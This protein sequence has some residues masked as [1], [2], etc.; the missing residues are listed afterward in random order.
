MKIKSILPHL[1][2]V[3]LFTIIS[4]AY[5][6]PVLEG[7]VLKANDSMVA[8]INAKE[9]QDFRQEFGKEPLWTNALFS[10]M[11][12][13]LISTKYPGNIFK[14]IDTALRIYGMP[15][16]VLFLSMLGFYFLLLMLGVNPWLSIAGGVGYGLSSFLLQI[17]AAG[18]N[19]QAV[20]LA[21][22]APLIGGVW[23][24]YRRDVIKGA[25]FTAF[26][27]ALELIANH[28]Q[29]TYYSFIILLI[30]IIS[31]FVYSIKEKTILSFLK[32]SAIMIIP[33]VLAVGINFGFLYT[34]Y[35][36]GKYSMRGKSDL[37]TESKNYSSGLKK[38]Y[39]TQWS[40]G[41]GE[42][43]NLLVPDFKGG[44]SHP[45][46]RDSETYKLLRKNGA[47]QAD[48]PYKYWGTQPGTEG[49]H[50]LGAIVIFLFILG[51]ILVKGRDKWWML[52]ATLLSIMLAWGSNFMPLTD[53]FVDYF[54]GYNKFRSVTFILVIAQFCVPLLGFL[55]LKELFYS[56]TPGK[57]LM[58]GFLTALSITSGLLLLFL[59]FPGIA[60]SFLN[61]FESD[62]PDVVKE[63]LVTDRRNLLTSDALRSLLF[64]LAGAG[65][66]LAA[67]YNKLKKEYAILIV[68][69]LVLVD[70][71]SV[72]K[73]YLNAD[74]FF[75]PAVMQKSFTPTV[76][77]QEILKDKSH[78]R[79][80]NRSVSSFN[81][82]SPTS[83]FHN[84]IG[85]YHG[86]KLRRYQEVIDSAMG[87]DI[88][89]FDSTV[90][91][92]RSEED[93]V[94]VFEKTPI[95]NMLNTKY[96]IFHPSYPPLLN[97]KA[98]G[99]AWFVQEAMIAE[100]A[101]AELAALLSIDP[102]REA[103]IDMKFGDLVT[104]PKYTLE[105]G[106]KIE[107]ESVRSNELVYR[108]SAKGE[109]LAV[110][111]EI[112][113]PSGW[114]AFID[115]KESEHFRADYVLR[116]MV[117]PGGDHEVRFLFD[118]S[119]YKNGNRISLASSLLLILLLAGY[120]AMKFMKK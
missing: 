79:V 36:Y 69:L 71:W 92:V 63:T 32:K 77:D 43:F 56:E 34:T 45:V 12:A 68:G 58:K 52:I 30:F 66:I 118:P 54:P 88:F 86:A 18:H 74:R 29:M 97:Q 15:V 60:G 11:P 120:G 51:L 5:F 17:I 96:I 78:F 110:F 21:Y 111:S 24:A 3:V 64:I 42:T 90:A 104:A 108:Y 109:R 105:E 112:Y 44:S 85:G 50:Y 4:F 113:Y 83:Y 26:I 106:D 87:R 67:M 61:P 94:T 117:L 33:V 38:D 98:L 49:P 55:A 10:G 70:L 82:N 91:I 7:K 20:A 80:W 47:S 114:K 101:N 1:I 39:I 81:D 57:K 2:A 19:T 93:L 107:L 116:A 46:D 13:Y 103:V 119:S 72:D 35:D 76:A 53:L 8:K 23:Y 27:L 28:P 62:Y 59:V 31:E 22:M 102:A 37:L 95:L 6:Y 25:L 84:S 41:I 9:I 65:I 16:A 100:N 75:K 48:M 14:H 73:R 99:N 40:Y 115:G 89:R